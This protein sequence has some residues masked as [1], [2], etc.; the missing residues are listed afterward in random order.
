MIPAPPDLL[1]I[2]GLT[3]DRFADGSSA[4]G[5]SVLHVARAAAAQ[6]VRL[7]IVTA[8]GPEPAARQALAELRGVD[9]D[10]ASTVGP[11][12]THFRHAETEAGRTLWLER[13]GPM[14]AVADAL[15]RLPAMSVLVAPIAGEIDESTLAALPDVPRGAILQGWL[16]TT[17]VNAAVRPL[18]L[19]ALPRS[20]AERL[21]GFTLLVA[22]REDLRGE[23]VEPPEQL[24]AI[25]AFVGAGPMLMLTDGTRGAWIDDGAAVISVGVPRVVEGVPTIGAG[26]VFAAFALLALARPGTTPRAAA[27]EAMQ[28]VV[29][30][31]ERGATDC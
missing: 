18:P 27:A 5:G 24:R 15:A 30:M 6:G 8:A 7:G 17:E 4:P 21:A 16:R 22:S 14:V 12:T 23:A 31:L 28:A 9:P 20:L 25:R 19:A 1:V 26:D 10:L 2:G 3:I 11:A 29:A 13:R